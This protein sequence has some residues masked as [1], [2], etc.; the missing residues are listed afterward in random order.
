MNI[1]YCATSIGQMLSGVAKTPEIIQKN[2]KNIKNYNKNTY[3]KLKLINNNSSFN[4]NDIKLENFSN[5]FYNAENIYYNNSYI[6]SQNK[7]NINIGGDHSI[8]LGS[9]PASIDKYKDDL[10]VIWIDA[11]ADLNSY[12]S[13]HSKNSHGMPLYYLINCESY[14]YGSWLYDNQ[15]N[16]ENLLYIGIRDLD[17]FEMEYINKN[18]IKNIS[19]NRYKQINDYKEHFYNLSNIISNKKIH[20]SIDVDGLD[21]SY[22]A[23]TGTKYINGVDIEYVIEL[24]KFFKKNIVNVD[25]VELNL[26]LGTIEEK[27]IS[28]ENFLKIL[29]T[30]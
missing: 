15:L 8:A 26:D 9:I 28:L 7:L 25:L 5:T 27:E 4:Y 3:K 16:K 18:H 21:P 29:N 24:I 10:F 1:S 19:S 11:H 17:R 20:L 22:I 13:S 30:F 2:I 6:L 12:E 14:I 23:S